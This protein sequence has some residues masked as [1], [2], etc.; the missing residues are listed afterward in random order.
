MYRII[1]LFILIFFLFPG[2]CLAAKVSMLIHDS[3]TYAVQ[4]AIN[5][6]DLPGEIE[7][8]SFNSPEN[9]KEETA[10]QEY[11]SGS[12]VILLDIMGS[13][14][15][16]FLLRNVDIESSQVYALNESRDDEEL[17]QKGVI[18]DKDIR[19][20]FQYKSVDNLRN[21][22][23][24]ALNKSLDRGISFQEPAERPE[25]GIYHP[26]AGKIFTEFSDYLQWYRDDQEY[27]ENQPWIGVLLYSSCLTP[28]KQAAYN[29]CLHRLQRAGF[30]ILPCYGYARTKEI[31]SSYF[32]DA[33][34]KSRIEALLS[35]SL[36]FQSGGSQQVK[37]A[38][39]ELNVPVINAIKLFFNTV[40]EWKEDPRGI[41]PAGVVTN[42]ANPEVSGLIEPSPLMGKSKVE[43]SESGDIYKTVPVKDNVEHLVRRLKKWI[44]LRSMDNEDKKVAILYYNHHQGKQNIGASYLNVFQSLSRILGRM[45]SLGYGIEN[46]QSLEKK[47]LKEL[48]LEFGRNVGSWAP[49]E[50]EKMVGQGRPVKVSVQRYKQWF[51]DLP[52]GFRDKVIEEWGTPEE[53]EIMKRNNKFIIPVID[54]GNVVIMPEPARGWGDN[55]KKLYHDPVLQPHHQYIAAYIW[56]QKELQADAMIHLGTHATHEWLP[57]KQAGLSRSC[58]PEVLI[59]DIPNLYPY[60]VDDVGEGIQAKRR[61]RGVIID[62]LTPPLRQGGLYNEYSRLYQ[63]I[64]RLNRSR[65]K[66]AKTV[67]AQKEKVF[68][69]TRELGIHKDL[70][71]EELGE[72][73]LEDIEHYLLDIKENS[74]PFGLH[75]FGRSPEG[76]PLQETV[77][78]VREQNSKI[79]KQKL[80]KAFLDS[81]PREMDNLMRGLDGEYIPSGQGNDPVRNPEAVPTGKNF[82]GFDPEKI[83]SESAWE[84]GKQAARDIIKSSM[85]KNG[86]YPEKVAVTLWAT[87]T[88]RNGGINTSTILY[89]LGLKPV[90]DNTG[91]ITGTRVIPGEKLDRPRI[92]VLVNP[93]GLFRDLFPNMLRMLDRAVQKAMVQKDIRNLLRENSQDIRDQMLEAGM[94]EKKAEKMSRV[95]IFTGKPGSYGTGVAEMTGNSGAW[96]SSEKV[97]QVYKNRQGYAYGRG[98]WGESAKELFK[99]NLSDVDAAVHSR[100]SNVYG[101]MDND[102]MFQYLGGMSM[103]VRQESGEDPDTLVTMNRDPDSADVKS[104]GQ[105]I[106]RELRTRYLNP[107]WVQG[108]KE[109]GY[110]GA[111]E[112]NNFV[113][114]MWGW[115]VTTP[116]SVDDD[117]WRQTY[118]VYVKDKYGQDIKEFMNENNPWAYNSITA[119]M[120]E[121]IRKGYWDAG[122]NAKKK[123]A[124]EYAMNVVKKGVACCDHTCNNP[125]LNQMVANIIS[126][127]GV[128]SPEM[129]EKFKLAMEQAAGKKLN[130]QVADRKKLLQ[131]LDKGRKSSVPEKKSSRDRKKKTA[132]DKAAQE[133]KKGSKQKKVEGYKMEK[134]DKN[135]QE[136][137]KVSSSGVQWFASVFV[138]LVLGIVFWGAGKRRI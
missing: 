96:N 97:G 109:E 137:A 27:K 88:I 3:D 105:V 118:Q 30:N 114:Y 29:Y 132:G 7:V 77:Q 76:D 87:E 74:M 80:K 2:L 68:S 53:C 12:E 111:R 119:R 129:V 9:I 128:M 14:Y 10:K 135:K 104:A 69:L 24:R 66:G 16:D 20:Y 19:A 37:N 54:L 73:N 6:L 89:L 72:E 122:E 61:G 121:S 1:F 67:S 51:S 82:Y 47:D 52:A 75:T 134:K 11:I 15:R 71:V 100:S 86:T 102:D 43:T 101:M 92:D 60:I 25:M 62:H 50:L 113:E 8:R 64:S 138:L 90:R 59:T 28:G 103:A 70:G 18:F 17:R 45:E 120:L 117:K 130:K 81:G 85:R 107:K 93:S 31:I 26:D 65:S 56:L 36:K 46:G 35:F 112:M 91:R 79:P 83:P 40:E 98:M 78:V 99:R 38:L 84:L 48:I 49:G 39:T 124:S 41:A 44:D 94:G 5:G 13:K 136:S 4:K 131:E 108:M 33:D 58:P 95:R 123:L 116:K 32:Q 22:I 110:A 106:G 126:M 55:P 127:P 34:K 133:G 42:I 21:M 23:R 57:G 115:Q 125:M 63:M